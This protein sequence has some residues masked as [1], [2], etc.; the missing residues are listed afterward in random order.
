M[1]REP[2]LITGTSRGIGKGIALKFA[3]NEINLALFGRNKEIL[4]SVAEYC[5]K[6][7]VEV[8]TFTGDVANEDFVA[9]SIAE[10]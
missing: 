4:E 3:E 9:K 8:I 1:S 6:Y 10:I 2:A 7:D 5:R